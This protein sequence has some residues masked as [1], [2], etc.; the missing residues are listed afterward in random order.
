MGIRPSQKLFGRGSRLETFHQQRG[1]GLPFALGFALV[2]QRRD[3]Q[4]LAVA[5]CQVAVQGLEHGRRQGIVLDPG[6]NE[7]LAPA[8]H[9]FTQLAHKPDEIGTL[10]D[11]VGAADCF[12]DNVLAIPHGNADPVAVDEPP[13][14]VSHLVSHN[15]W[16]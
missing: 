12:D 2:T 16:V 7:F 11:D 15:L 1:T 3:D 9:F 6:V 13:A 4:Q 5:L 8:E 14:L 10:F